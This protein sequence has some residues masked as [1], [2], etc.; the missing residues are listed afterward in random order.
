MDS[1]RHPD[2]LELGR[3]LGSLYET[4]RGA[5]IAAAAIADRRHR[6]LWDRFI[7]WEDRGAE[8]EVGVGH[9]AVAGPVVVGADH[10]TVGAVTIPFDS[11]GWARAAG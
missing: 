3:N 7:E 9:L 1:L 4:I 10:V 8:V 5:Q 11:I 6:T 2:L